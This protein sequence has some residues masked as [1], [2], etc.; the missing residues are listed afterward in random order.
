VT[1]MQPERVS[2]AGFSE[3]DFHVVQARKERLD[4]NLIFV[5]GW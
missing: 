4:S 3:I 2:P 5:I 1:F